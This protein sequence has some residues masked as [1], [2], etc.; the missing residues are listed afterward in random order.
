MKCPKC[1]K[2]TA[3]LC[4][5]D[6]ISQARKDIEVII[7]CD[8]ICMDRSD[9]EHNSPEQVGTVNIDVIIKR[10]SI[11]MDAQNHPSPE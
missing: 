11:K 8:G 4:C 5:G 6:E 7:R 10:G 2:N 1:G 9:P 3:F